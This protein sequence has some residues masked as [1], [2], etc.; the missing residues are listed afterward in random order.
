VKVL[1]LA[2]PS[3]SRS[4]A[5][6]YSFQQEEALALQAAGHELYVVS[7]HGAD[8]EVDGLRV[9]V[10]PPGRAWRERSGTPLFLL[11]GRAA[12]PRGM[13]LRDWATAF[14][15]ARIERF[16]ARLVRREG[17]ALVHSHFAWPDGIGGALAAAGARRPLIASFRGMDLD[18]HEGLAYGMRRDAAMEHAIRHLI[19]RADRTTYVSEYLRRIGLSLGADP[20]SAVTI[21]KGVDLARFSPAPDRAALRQS[22][23][24]APPLLMSVGGL[25]KLKGIHYVLDALASLKATHHFTYVVVGDGE[26]RESLQAQAARLGLDERI[27]FL[28][29]L[30]RGRIPQYFAAC[31]LL[32]LGSLTEGSGNVALE[33]MASG[34]PVVATDSGGPPEYV[35]DG[36]TGFVVPVADVAA[37]AERVRR[38]LDAPDLADALGRAGRRRMVEGFSYSRMI[39]QI[40]ALYEEVV[41]GPSASTSSSAQQ[42]HV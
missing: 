3:E 10:L 20:A 32:V 42:P 9:R 19:R 4:G 1:Y 41:R 40:D 8:R 13:R 7:H 29:R 33:A 25:Q 39:G 6:A 34:R 11:R 36:E 5:L 30:D 18:V 21:L 12:F 14:H 2:P 28:G 22:L 16:A 15:L 31:D 17:I 38:L 24:F 23:G 35:S 26:E 37:M 27:R